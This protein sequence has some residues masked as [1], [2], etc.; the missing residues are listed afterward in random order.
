MNAAVMASMLALLGTPLAGLLSGF[1]GAMLG[2][3]II[4]GISGGLIATSGLL[5]VA[6]AVPMLFL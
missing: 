4:V 2:G 5:L 1:G 3:I 6:T